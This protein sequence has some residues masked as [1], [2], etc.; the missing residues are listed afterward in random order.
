ML[1]PGSTFVHFEIL[2][3]LGRGTTGIVYKVRDFHLQ[4]TVA[5]KLPLISSAASRA[6]VSALF[7]HE[8]QVLAGLTYKPN[9]NIPP[10]HEVGE[11]D[12]QPYCIREYVEGSTFEEKVAGGSID[13]HKGLRVLEMIAR[14]AHIIH[15]S[16]FVHRNLHSS[17]VLISSDGTPKLIGFGIVALRSG[18]AIE[19]PGKEVASTEIDL[20]TLQYMLTWLYSAMHRSLPAHIKW[21]VHGGAICSALEFAD[22]LARLLNDDGTF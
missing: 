8:C 5:L 11:H 7:F 21:I 12:G 4:R 17:N 2:A 9:N 14:T 3:E 15:L 22:T 13:L 6:Y 20:A 16:G 10:L 18:S 19:Q 1:V